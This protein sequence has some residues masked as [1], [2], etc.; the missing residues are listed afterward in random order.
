M[1]KQL[2]AWQWSLYSD[3]HHDR[4]NLILHVLTVPLFWAGTVALGLAW[5]TPWLLL[6]GPVAMAVAMV[7]QG[8]GHRRESVAPVPFDGAGDVLSRI[9]VE[10]WVTFP[11]YLLS[12]GF[13]RAWRDAGQSSR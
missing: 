2:V 11:R 6:A 1:R 12:G 8:R 13:A 3:N 10:Q 4:A 5:I 9:F 7:I